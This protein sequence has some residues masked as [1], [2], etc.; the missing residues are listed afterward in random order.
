MIKSDPN[1]FASGNRESQKGKKECNCKNISNTITEEHM[2]HEATNITSTPRIKI[3]RKFFRSRSISLDSPPANLVASREL[4]PSPPPPPLPFIQQQ[5]TKFMR[6]SSFS[7]MQKRGKAQEQTRDHSTRSVDNNND[8]C[9]SFPELE[10]N[11]IGDNSSDE[12]DEEIRRF[13]EGYQ[14]LK[15]KPRFQSENLMYVA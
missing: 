9:L 6:S 14:K 3:R 4:F 13:N 5:K 12:A 8:I 2:M 15:I 11:T 7:K 10:D 1:S